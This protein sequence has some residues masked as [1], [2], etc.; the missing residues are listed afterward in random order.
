MQSML[1]NLQLYAYLTKGSSLMEEFQDLDNFKMIP[2]TNDYPNG[3]QY[4]END[5]EYDSAVEYRQ[6]VDIYEDQWHEPQYE[7]NSSIHN[8]HQP[9]Y[10]RG[11]HTDS[12]A[13]ENHTL[14]NS[15]R[16]PDL[17]KQE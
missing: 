13:Y 16:F 10:F 8:R 4:Q 5:F 3:Y 14:P 9:F 1:S 15:R 6:G 7:H 11:G 17:S 12:E 2:P